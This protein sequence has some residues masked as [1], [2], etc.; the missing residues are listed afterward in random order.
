LKKG[1]I[2]AM[3]I[4]MMSQSAYAA[5]TF[6]ENADT[7]VMTV[8]GTLEGTELT[9]IVSL[10]IENAEGKNVYTSFITADG[11]SFEYDFKLADD[12]PTGKYTL[13]FNSYGLET[14]EKVEIYYVSVAETNAIITALNS[15]A[16]ALTVKGVLDT[17]RAA[18]GIS[19]RWYSLLSD[20][21]KIVIADALFAAKGTG[22]QN[23]DIP[24][25][26]ENVRVSHAPLA[27]MAS[28][29]EAD[30]K[31]ALS[32][33]ADL[34]DISVNT[35]L[36]AKYDAFSAEDAAYARKLMAENKDNVTDMYTLYDS[37]VLLAEIS[38]A[39]QPLDILNVI[40]GN[41]NLITFDL[42]TFDIS[43]K[44]TTAQYL[45]GKTYEKMS[46]L[47][48]QIANAYQAQIVAIAPSGGSSGGSSGSGSGKGSSSIVNIPAPQ[49]PDIVV[50]ENADIFTDLENAQWAK[51]AINH[52]ANE[53]II[54]GVGDKKF[55]PFGE[56]TREQFAVMLVK[57]FELT[58]NSA[59]A[60]FADVD[61]EHWA[62]RAIAS[63]YKAGIVNGI[64]DGNFGLG[65]KIKR[66]DIA[67]MVKAA[68]DKCGVDLS[69]YNAVDL[70]D[71]DDLPGYAK[72]S[73][74][75]MIKA[76]II[77][78]FAED[79]TFRGSDTA[80]RAQA[81]QIIYTVLQRKDG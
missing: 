60:E 16:D 79:N 3:V 25:I 63:A 28:E 33:F 67:V 1:I 21:D 57:A 72:A 8:S 78:G 69:G 52:L 37:S 77:N 48:V 66:Q 15:A 55:D 68:A 47:Q 73:V 41:R 81:A 18:L 75:T 45:Y 40:E 53:K 24:D 39:S 13:I 27:F 19:E 2:A 6:N 56:V 12:A 74:E 70:A 17:H 44:A 80:T 36:S 29:N 14:P 62:Y 34:Y 43:N 5:V 35:A 22:Y 20:E 58:D 61:S 65:Q 31:T 46:D 38:A 50:D 30:I 23:S 10:D 71:I 4:A 11:G 59:E 51:K 64:G 32:Q 7:K 26:I 54:S 49:K 76:G 9:N 42:S